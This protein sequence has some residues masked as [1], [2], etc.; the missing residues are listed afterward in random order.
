MTKGSKVRKESFVYATLIYILV[1]FFLLFEMALQVSPSV[2]TKALMRDFNIGAA[3]LGFVISFYYYS[4]TILQIPVGLLYDRFRARFLVTGALFIC[5]AGSLLFAFTQS[6][7]W[8]AASR[9]MMGIG[10]AFAFVGVLIVAARWFP[11]RYFAFLVGTAQFLAAVGALCGELPIAW[12][13]EK[14][15]WRWVLVLFALIGLFLTLLSFLFV[16]ENPKGKREVPK[17]HHLI[18]ELKEIIR[19]SQTWWIGL[20]AFCGW[21]PIAVFAALWGVPYLQLRFNVSLSMAAF[22]MAMVWIGIGTMSPLL[23][24]LS[25]RLGKRCKLLQIASLVGFVFSIL[26]LYVPGVNFGLVFLLLFGIGLAA[27][28]QILTFALVKDN[29]RP[30]NLGTAIGLNNMAVVAGGAFFQPL[31]GFILHFLWNGSVE[32]SGVPLY[33]IGNY[34]GALFI[35]PLC[36]L[37]SFLASL[38]FIEETNCFPKYK[39]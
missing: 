27:S 8:I 36:F 37:I 22:A 3:T 25:D 34:H 39:D 31:V 33:T 17:K 4:Y 19:S 24:Y 5:S 21:G 35:V 32:K 1:S 30:A 20:Y 29:T 12:L 13:L 23:G 14:F 26:L 11:A 9:F 18:Q 38:F 6:L 2:M 16:R 15:N 7:A 28:G 10:S